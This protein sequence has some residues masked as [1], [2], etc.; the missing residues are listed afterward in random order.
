MIQQTLFQLEPEQG[1]QIVLDVKD[2]DAYMVFVLGDKE[3]VVEEEDPQ[4]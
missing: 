3:D 2:F 4:D 1:V